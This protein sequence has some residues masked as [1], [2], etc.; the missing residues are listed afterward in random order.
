MLVVLVKASG[1]GIMTSFISSLFI[2][3]YFIKQTNLI[4]LNKIDVKVKMNIYLMRTYPTKSKP[5]LS[6]KYWYKYS[7]LLFF[8]F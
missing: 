3:L 8:L 2:F 7:E 4:N 5:Y 1:N 6:E